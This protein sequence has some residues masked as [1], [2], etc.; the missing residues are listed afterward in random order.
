MATAKKTRKPRE[1]GPNPA[2][3]I[4]CLP[5]PALAVIVGERPLPRTE[6]V[7][8]VWAYVRRHKLQDP[9]EEGMINADAALTTVFGGRRRVSM[10]E[11]T[12][13]LND[14]L[15]GMQT[16][17]AVATTPT[18]AKQM[19][20]LWL[21][22]RRIGGRPKYAKT[23]ILRHDTYETRNPRRAGVAGYYAFEIAVSGLTVEE[24][25]YTLRAARDARPELFQKTAREGHKHL[26]WDVEHGFVVAVPYDDPRVEGARRRNQLPS[27]QGPVPHDFDMVKWDIIDRLGPD[28][29]RTS[30]SPQGRQPF[31]FS[32]RPPSPGAKN[33]TSSK[34]SRPTTVEL[35]HRRLQEAV[36][37]V[38]VAQNGSSNVGCEQVSAA[39]TPMDIVVKEGDGYRVYE[40][41][42]ASTVRECVREALGQLLEYAYWPGSPSINGLVVVAEAEPSREEAEFVA[43]LR[44]RFGLPLTYERWNSNGEQLWP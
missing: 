12:K 36:Y 34:G 7:K 1:G 40:L 31:V 19:P 29:P 35:R 16:H 42:S 8:R 10:F 28:R 14:N 4:P 27:L 13:L 25:D 32:A 9:E 20:E 30:P 23:A 21:T 41:K 24:Y 3:M 38:L 6:A 5:S 43:G 44:D 39:G 15:F 22:Q 2:F 33:E 26:N 11:M 37:V 17:D 18:L